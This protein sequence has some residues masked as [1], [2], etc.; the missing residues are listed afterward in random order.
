MSIQVQS[1]VQALYNVYAASEA[2]SAVQVQDSRQ[3]KAPRKDDVVL[4]E[5]GRTF[6]EILNRLKADND[7]V[8]KDKVDLYA[9]RIAAGDYHV[10]AHD[11]AARMIDQ[12]I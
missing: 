1:C 12:R 3:A 10:A 5:E 11:I 6:G 9:E 2:F 7:K 4:S 8:R